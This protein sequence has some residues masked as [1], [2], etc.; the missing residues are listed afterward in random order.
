[1]DYGAESNNVTSLHPINSLLIWPSSDF[2]CD[3]HAGCSE[4]SQIVMEKAGLKVSDVDWFIPHQA[5]Q[6]IME[7]VAGITYGAA[8]F[9]Y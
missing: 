6:R 3:G 4:S 2:F 8:T 7:A 9:E 1:M 5:N